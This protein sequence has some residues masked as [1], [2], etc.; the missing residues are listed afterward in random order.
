MNLGFKYGLFTAAGLIVY[1]LLMNVFGLET[2]LVLRFFNFFIIIFGSYLVLRKLY[3]SDNPLPTY[4]EG[5]GISLLHCVTAVVAFVLFLAGY[6]YAVNP[7]FIQ[8]LEE[9]H[10]WGNN[11]AIHEAAFAILIE[12]IA[13]GAAISFAWMQYF[14][15]YIEVPTTANTRA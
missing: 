15:R 2:N 7:S 8:I 9:S 5:L 14:K 6:I 1:F 13:S 12:G 10:I 3:K 4:V 11:L